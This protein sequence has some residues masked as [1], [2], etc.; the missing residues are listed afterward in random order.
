MTYDCVGIGFGPSN[1]ALAVALRERGEI[2]NWIFLESES[3]FHWHEGM[4][5]EGSDIQHNPLRDFV[6][7]RNPCSEY[8]FLSFLKAKGRLFDYL[9]LASHYPPRSEYAEYVKWVAEQFRSHVALSTRVASIV[10]NDTSGLIEIRTNNPSLGAIRAKSIVFGTGRSEAVPEMYENLLGPDVVHLKDYLPAKKRW[11]DRLEQPRICVLGGSQ[12]AIEIVLDLSTCADV[13]SVSRSF[14]FK[15]KDL[16]AFTESIYYPEFVNYFYNSGTDSQ[17]EIMSELWRSNYGA[18][19]PDVIEHLNFKLYEQKVRNESY[20]TVLRNTLV[21]DV[22]QLSGQAGYQL[23]LLDK[24]TGC[25]TTID[26]DGIVL[27]TGYKNFG[28]GI[29]QEP[30]H[31]LLANLMSQNA[32]YRTDGGIEIGHDYRVAFKTTQPTAVYVNGLC[33]ASHGF[34][35]AGSFSLLSVRSDE[36]AQS[37]HQFLSTHHTSEIALTIPAE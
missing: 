19:D 9:N 5:I 20:L 15:Q 30:Y 34:G 28:S 11:C 32:E 29:G 7:P 22:T 35:D 10:Q 2:D 12:S 24:Y 16:S 14:G 6:T 18:A 37:L 21:Q 27:A 23:S 4:L 25:K 31:P 26:V 1:I 13:T 33:E 36:I 8:G 3:D 17:A